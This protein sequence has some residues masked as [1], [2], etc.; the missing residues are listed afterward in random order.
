MNSRKRLRSCTF[1]IK[2]A[3]DLSLKASTSSRPSLAVD[4]LFN[5]TKTPMSCSASTR[6]SGKCTPSKHSPLA[7]SI[8]L[9]HG[10]LLWILRLPSW[11]LDSRMH[12]LSRRIK[13][14]K[15]LEETAS[16]MSCTVE[17]KMGKLSLLFYVPGYVVVPLDLLTSLSRS[18]SR[19]LS[20]CLLT[21][22][23]FDSE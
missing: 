17:D 20:T 4:V 19:Y 10:L 13:K 7:D 2:Q 11:V 18:L 14:Q 6:R 23:S 9:R 8:R 16:K 21:G 3:T 1:R 5:L 15:K 12:A 22:L